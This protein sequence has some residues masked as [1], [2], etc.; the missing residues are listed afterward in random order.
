MYCSTARQIFLFECWILNVGSVEE[1]RF[2]I[3]ANK[4]RCKFIEL[5]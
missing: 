5:L 1:L 4:H 2:I 3:S